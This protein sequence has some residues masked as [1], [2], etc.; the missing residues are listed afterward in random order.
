[1]TRQQHHPVTSSGLQHLSFASRFT[2]G[3]RPAMLLGGLVLIWW[4]YLVLGS[5]LAW[6]SVAM[7]GTV[8]V[9]ILLRKHRDVAACAAIA[10][11]T[12]A[13]PAVTCVVLVDQQV[14]GASDLVAVLTGYIF[15]APVPALVAVALRPALFRAPGN[16]LLGSGVL[17]LGAAVS[18]VVG[19][20]GEGAVVLAAALTGS[21]GLVWQRHR[22]AAGAVLS[23]LPLVNGWADLGRRALPDGSLIDR[24]LVGNGHAIACSFLPSAAVSHQESAALDATHTAA[25]AAVAL[26]LAGSR[27][28]PALLTQGKNP[29][30]RRYVVNDGEVAASVILI[31]EHTIEEVTRLAPHR[32]RGQRHALLAGALLPVPRPQASTT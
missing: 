21:V 16:A 15:I 31:P 2:G 19:D 22:R 4:S 7:A 24:L 9:V 25:A 11:I 10:A 8:I 27:V 32:R 6:L 3:S 29:Y 14:A 12:A 26:G 20:H 23:G 5:N 18:V 1:M 30:P 13:V 28:Q 17:L